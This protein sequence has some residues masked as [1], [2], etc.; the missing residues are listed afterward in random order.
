MGVGLN[1]SFEIEINK[2]NNKVKNIVRLLFLD[3]GVKVGV[4]IVGE[5]LKSLGIKLEY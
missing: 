2:K 1:F 4:M 3:M 5:V